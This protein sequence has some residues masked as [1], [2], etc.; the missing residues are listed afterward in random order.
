MSTGTQMSQS[1]KQRRSYEKILKK[2]DPGAHA[3]FKE[4]SRLRGIELHRQN[5]EDQLRRQEE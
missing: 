1:R 5:I 3:K 2:L 4:E